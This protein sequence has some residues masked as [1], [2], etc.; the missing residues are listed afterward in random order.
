MYKRKAVNHVLLSEHKWPLEAVSFTRLSDVFKSIPVA[1]PSK[2]IPSTIFTIE[3]LA[4][5]TKN[6]NWADGVSDS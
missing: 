2:N 1:L 5:G 6:R 3:P 4:F